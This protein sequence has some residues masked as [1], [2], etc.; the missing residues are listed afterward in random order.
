MN[1]PR[2]GMRRALELG[3]VIRARETN[4]SYIKSRNKAEQ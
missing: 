2:E 1:R 4:D 3:R